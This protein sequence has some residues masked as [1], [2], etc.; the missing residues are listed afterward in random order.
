V[1]D[2][3]QSEIPAKGAFPRIVT[4]QGI[5]FSLQKAFPHQPTHLTPACAAV[6]VSLPYQPAI[7]FRSATAALQFSQGNTSGEPVESF[8][9]QL[10]GL[11]LGP[12]NVH[13]GS[14]AVLLVAILSNWSQM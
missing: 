3:V 9:R 2:F 4:E 1:T 12:M 10:E 13:I 14:Y 6:H 11:L 8:V 5:D 7:K